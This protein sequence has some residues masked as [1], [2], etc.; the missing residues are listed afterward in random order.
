MS[1]PPIE[2]SPV[3]LTTAAETVATEILGVPVNPDAFV[4]L[5]AL[6]AVSA[7]PVTSPVTSPLNV[8][9]VI[10]PV[11]FAPWGK[12]G[13]PCLPYLRN[14]QTLLLTFGFTLPRKFFYYL[15]RF[16]INECQYI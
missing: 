1:E 2:T 10:T 8:V 14:Y 11:I 15:Y 16:L 9:A 4:A 13:L 3:V 12:L 5:V 6:V 7:L